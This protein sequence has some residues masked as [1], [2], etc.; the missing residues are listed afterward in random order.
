MPGVQV[1]SLTLEKV[2]VTAPD[3]SSIGAAAVSMSDSGGEMGVILMG[4]AL[5]QPH[6]LAIY[7]V[8]RRDRR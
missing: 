2:Q 4:A 7:W 5:I 8:G 6:R 3:A 1:P